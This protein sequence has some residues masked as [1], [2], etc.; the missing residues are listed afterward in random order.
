VTWL[1]LVALAVKSGDWAGIEAS[2]R[3]AVEAVAA[4]RASTA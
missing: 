2:T 3:A 1:G 4:F